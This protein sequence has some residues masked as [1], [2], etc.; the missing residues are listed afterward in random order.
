MKHIKK[1]KIF[2]SK[3]DD[4]LNEVKEC[5]LPV[6]DIVSEDNLKI[7]ILGNNHI[8]IIANIKNIKEKK[9]LFNEITDSI[10]Q[11]RTFDIKIYYI[12]ISYNNYHV[13]L[14][15]KALRKKIQKEVDDFFKDL[16]NDIRLEKIEI[17]MYKYEKDQAI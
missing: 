17:S 4:F 13:S 5:F 14:R 2:E 7:Y 11:L 9:E 6:I 16:T 3:D 1:Y 8:N 12:K 10:Y 15:F